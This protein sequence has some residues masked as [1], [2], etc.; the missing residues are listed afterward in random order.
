M[1]HLYTGIVRNRIMNETEF[2]EIIYRSI[3]VGM[4][5]KKPKK[6]SVILN[7]T[8]NGNI[9]YRIGVSNQ[10]V[11]TKNELSQTYK[12]LRKGSLSRAHLYEI[13]TSAK[14]CNANTIKW[15]LTHSGLAKE[16]DIGGLVKSQW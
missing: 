1:D 12:V 4:V 10:K 15:L 9:H 7:I 2:L 3:E 6:D 13:V 8:E 16:N 11:V 14:P 5:I